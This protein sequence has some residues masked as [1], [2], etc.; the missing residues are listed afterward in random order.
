MEQRDATGRLVA[1]TRVAA[2]AAVLP[3]RGAGALLAWRVARTVDWALWEAGDAVVVAS[4]TLGA[5]AAGRFLVD[6]L[7]ATAAR[8]GRRDAPP[9]TGRAA[10]TVAASLVAV[11]LGAGAA[12]ALDA[13]PSAGWL[14]DAPAAS[15]APHDDVAAA[16]AGMP[17]TRPAEPGAR[18]AVAAT[19][20]VAPGES[21]WAITADALAEG[22][23]DAA[24]A[25]AWPRLYAANRD[26]VGTD[27]GLIHPGQRL[28]MPAGLTGARR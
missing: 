22:A 18:S 4:G 13:P 17:A 2:G 23:T 1:T 14:P 26:V 5:V 11:L 8:V 21:L 19:H 20:V 7:A 25:E 12:Q 6:V 3:H 16:P 27:P 15:E 28:R 24:V 10:R 9:W